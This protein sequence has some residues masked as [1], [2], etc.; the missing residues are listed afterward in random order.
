[1][2]EEKKSLMA[3]FSVKKE[4]DGTVVFQ[5]ETT[6]MP[7]YV[8]TIYIQKWAIARLGSPRRIKITIE[9]EA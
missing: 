7:P 1:M 3:T 2:T 5:E 9:A 6:D 4:T 8:K